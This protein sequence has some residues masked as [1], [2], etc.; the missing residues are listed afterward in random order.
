LRT[1]ATIHGSRARRSV[2]LPFSQA[3]LSYGCYMRGGLPKGAS[4]VGAAREHFR[5]GERD[6]YAKVFGELVALL[7]M[8]DHPD[9]ALGQQGT[10]PLL[11]V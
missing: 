8:K 9:F 4:G 1:H 6:P 2:G 10:E 3:V 7:A 11:R 5:R